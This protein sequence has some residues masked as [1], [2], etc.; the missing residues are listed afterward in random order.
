MAAE[1]VRV[2]VRC[3]PLNTRELELEC[4]NIIDIVAE[5]GQCSIKHPS[6]KKFPPKNF[7]FDGAFDISSTTEQIYSDICYP[8]VE[9]VTEGYNGTIF[10][11]GQTGCGKSFTMQGISEDASQR[12]IIPR[13]KMA[14]GSCLGYVYSIFNNGQGR[15]LAHSVIVDGGIK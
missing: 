12:G 13:F 11:Y 8:L 14:Y 3:R 9:G 5:T 1:S 10:A 2:I 15:K 4:K 6:D 7:F